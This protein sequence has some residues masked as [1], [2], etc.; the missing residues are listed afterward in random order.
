MSQPAIIKTEQKS[1]NTTLPDKNPVQKS[2]EF[3][4][5][6]KKIQ[7]SRKNE[8]AKKMPEN[9]N[10]LMPVLKNNNGETRLSKSFSEHQMR[11][12]SHRI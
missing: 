9:H 10:V 3:T 2:P 11:F 1:L 6:R 4:A 7:N 5:I 8:V 12:K